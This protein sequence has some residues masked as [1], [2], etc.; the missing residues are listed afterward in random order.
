MSELMMEESSDS[1]VEKPDFVNDCE[2][3][4]PAHDWRKLVNIILPVSV[5]ALRKELF[6]KS[7]FMDDFHELRKHYDLS[8][9]EWERCDEGELRRT[10]K[11][12]MPLTGPLAMGFG[13]KFSW[14]TQTQTENPCCVPNRLHVVEVVN[15]NENIPY[16]DVFEVQIHHCL[17][18]SVDRSDCSHH[19]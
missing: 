16:A 10:L 9:T 5:E 7:K 6:T 1:G 2:C 3:K 8:C 15:S 13:P 4:S 14:V 18:R 17:L 11:Y 12:K 19:D